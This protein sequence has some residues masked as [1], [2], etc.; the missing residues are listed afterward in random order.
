MNKGNY[1][2][3]NLPVKI[4]RA[5]FNKYIDPYLSRGRRGPSTKVSR[6][7]IFNYIL[8]VLDTGIQWDRLPTFRRE[9]S[10]SGI[11]YHHARW[12]KDGSYRNLFESSVQRLL[13]ANKLDLSVLHGD[14][15]NTTAKKGAKTSDTAATNIRKV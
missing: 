9:I 5:D 12:S 7:K 1:P 2:Q 15:S 6:Y 3:G 11:Y 13:L 4:G 10:W 8:F 14:G